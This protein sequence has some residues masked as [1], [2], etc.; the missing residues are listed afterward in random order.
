MANPSSYVGL[1][2][3]FYVREKVAK[4]IKRCVSWS[5]PSSSWTDRSLASVA[6]TGRGYFAFPKST[7]N[8]WPGPRF[9]VKH[10]LP[11]AGLITGGLVLCQPAGGTSHTV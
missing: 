6:Q 11:Y 9:T 10:G 7:G 1:P 2:F 4:I 3:K 8:D 5:G